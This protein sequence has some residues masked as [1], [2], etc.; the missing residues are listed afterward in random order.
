MTVEEA[1]VGQVHPG[2]DV[3]L[4]RAGLPGRDLPGQSRH[5]RS[6]G[7]RARAHLRRQDRP[8][9]LRIRA[10]CR[11]CSPRSRWSRLKSRTPS[12]CPSEAVVQQGTQSVVFVNDN[13]KAQPAT[14][15][16]RYV[17]CH[18]DR[19]RLGP[20]SGRAGGRHRPE[21]AARRRATSRSSTRSAGGQG[22]QGGRGGQGG[23][24]Q[25]GQGG[26][27]GQA[28]RPGWSGWQAPLRVG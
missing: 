24:A 6:S 27:G 1:R 8:D 20:R 23:G 9:H 11:A 15:P 16:D 2:L 13:G 12:W 17:G 18:L 25:G 14:S 22:G 21:R 19:D 28:W 3:Q 26:Q 4:T 7:R 10:C 5:P